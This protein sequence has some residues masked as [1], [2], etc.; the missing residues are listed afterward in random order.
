MHC[1]KSLLFNNTD[2]G[3]KK[4]SNKNFDVTIGS[5]DSTEVCELIIL[6]I[7][8]IYYVTNMEKTLIVYI[9]MMG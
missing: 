4:E 8:Y 9:G 5:F 1:R 3:I 7:L 6:Y 2:I